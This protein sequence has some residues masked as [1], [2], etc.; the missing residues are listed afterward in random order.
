[1]LVRGATPG[2]VGE[3]NLALGDRMRS[4]EEQ[5]RSLLRRAGR[6]LFNVILGRAIDTRIRNQRLRGL[7]V[8]GEPS[9]LFV[10]PTAV[11]NNALFNT[12]SGRIAVED[13]AF[14]GHN[15]C[16]LTGTHDISSLGSARQSATPASGRDVVIKT[17]AWVASNA[18]VLGPCI[19]GE[20]AVVA[21]GAVV[22][23][24]VPAYSIVGGVPA[25]VIGYVPR[26]Q[27]ITSPNQVPHPTEAT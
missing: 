24:D 20:H 26:P 23:R 25:R 19:V 14:F 18:T 16:V 9:R 1:M 7:V 10:S 2:G 12:V 5:V 11:T 4:G 27:A 17:G 3:L 13:Y 15:V 6:R 22:V 8:F 21:A